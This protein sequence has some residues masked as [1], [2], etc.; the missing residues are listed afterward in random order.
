LEEEK[1]MLGEV[2]QA[3]RE[4]INHLHQDSTMVE[5]MARLVEEENR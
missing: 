2:L 4:A 3:G 1:I 5:R